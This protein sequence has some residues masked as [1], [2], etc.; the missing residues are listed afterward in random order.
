[1]KGKRHQGIFGMCS[2]LPSRCRTRPRPVEWHMC[3]IMP[4]HNHHFGM[5]VSR[6][7]LGSLLYA[8]LADLGECYVEH[9]SVK[10]LSHLGQH[11][12]EGFINNYIQHMCTNSPL[13]LLKY[14]IESASESHHHF[15]VVF[16]QGILCVAPP[17]Y[18]CRWTRAPLR[19]I[20]P[21]G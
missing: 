14:L 5:N 13:I 3:F 1:M 21:A 19:C 8:I 12:R 11:V 4:W 9:A 2:I 7:R 15:L 16:P 20:S 18:T 10:C 17:Y 6:T